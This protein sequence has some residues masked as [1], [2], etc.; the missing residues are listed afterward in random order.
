MRAAVIIAMLCTFGCSEPEAPE[1]KF[2]VSGEVRIGRRQG[3]PETTLSNLIVL[4]DARVAHPLVCS[5]GGEYPGGEELIFENVET[6]EIVHAVF[7]EGNPMLNRQQGN[8]VLHG[9]FECIQNWDRFSLMQPPKDYQFFVVS[10][11]E[12]DS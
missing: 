5:S 6:K 2:D 1:P 4:R 7:P 9:R 11:W 10:S 12:L 8:F 3:V